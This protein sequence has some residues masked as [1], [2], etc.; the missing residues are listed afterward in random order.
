MSEVLRRDLVALLGSEAILY[1]PEGLTAYGG[2][3][4]GL[5]P[6][7]PVLVA[8]PASCEE[9]ERLVHWLYAQ[10]VPMTPRGAGTGK[11]GGCIPGPDDVVISTER[12]KGGPRVNPND[13]TVTVGAG[14]VAA[15]LDIAAARHGLFYPPDP[16]SLKQ[17]SIGG[18]VATNA[19]G[20]RAVKYGLTGHYL[21]GLTMIGARGERIRAG[22]GTIKSVAGSN[23]TGLMLGSEGCFGLISELT[24]RLIPRPAAVCTAIA[25]FDDSAAAGEAVGHLMRRGLN[26]RTAELLDEL[27]CQVLRQQRPGLLPETG[28]AALIFE[29]DGSDEQAMDEL[30]AMAEACSD[31]REVLVAQSEAQRERIWAPRRKLSETLRSIA[32]HK[33]SEDIAVPR[34]RLSDCIA[35]CRA[36]AAQTPFKLAAYGHAG[37]GNLHIN[38][39]F[40]TAEDR[41][42]VEQLADAIFRIA[43]D[44]GGT[45]TGEHG[46]GLA[47]R[48]ALRWEAGPA[49]M[50]LE[51]R[52]KK[53]MDPAGL[54]NPGKVLL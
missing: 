13:M 8:R 6:R 34:G 30:A 7:P 35:A 47:K 52:L 22:A 29:A 18:N 44:M 1:N 27:S 2:D 20:P 19:G 37:D 46:I 11:A 53:A 23:F 25:T 45:I 10:G 3:Y 38:L 36:A 21:L 16:N 24:M 12:L 51:S 39:L 14:V 31:A 9:A 15:E 41:P 40:D 17:S 50:A 26:P 32:A 28:G 49:R 42:A 4:S 5:A 43:I 54:F 48:H 33:I